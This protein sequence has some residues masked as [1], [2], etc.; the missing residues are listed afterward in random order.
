MI[1]PHVAIISSFLLA[2]NNPSTLEGIVGRPIVEPP[3]VARVN[4]LA[5]PSRCKTEWTWFHGRS[6]Y[7]WIKKALD[8]FNSE[9]GQSELSLMAKFSALTGRLPAFYPSS[10]SPYLL[11]S[12]FSSHTSLPM[13]ASHVE[14]LHSP[15]TLSPNSSSS[16]S[17][18]GCSRLP[19]FAQA[20]RYTPPCTGRKPEIAMPC[21]VSHGGHSPP[22]LEQQASWLPSGVQSCD[23]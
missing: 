20:A 21:A 4:T 23:C 9:S 6:K 3:P 1:I 5:Y 14:V 22:F 16:S 7:L 8:T 12:H 19:L 13:S 15:Y 11:F 10:S 17:G 2:S 18:S